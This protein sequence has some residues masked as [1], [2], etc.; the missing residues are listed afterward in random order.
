MGS[1]TERLDQA[2]KL[3][4]S[5]PMSRYL[6]LELVELDEARA[7]KILPGHR[8]LLVAHKLI[9]E[10]PVAILPINRN[11]SYGSRLQEP[12]Q[13]SNWSPGKRGSIQDRLSLRFDAS[14]SAIVWSHRRRISIAYVFLSSGRNVRRTPPQGNEPILSNSYPRWP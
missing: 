12:R 11:R 7:V 3:V 6:G 4:G 13:T 5:D 1:D 8:L 10:F 2:R 9:P 14:F